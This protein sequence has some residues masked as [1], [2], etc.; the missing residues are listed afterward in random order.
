MFA[1]YDMIV[2]REIVHWWSKDDD[3]HVINVK[4][5]QFLFTIAWINWAWIE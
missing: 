2:Y 4:I 5:I 3:E 1:K